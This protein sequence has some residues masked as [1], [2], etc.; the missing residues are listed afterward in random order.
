MSAPSQINLSLDSSQI[1]NPDYLVTKLL[2]TKLQVIFVISQNTSHSFSSLVKTHVPEV[3][4]MNNADNLLL[5]YSTSIA[6]IFNSSANETPVNT[7]STVN[8][9]TSKEDTSSKLKLVTTKKTEVKKKATGSIEQSNCSNQ[10]D[11]QNSDTISVSVTEKKRT[12]K[13][14]VLKKVVTKKS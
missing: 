11:K 14:L 3:Q 7:L 2:E 12:P 13:K 5:K 4:A 1:D 10:N 8:T 6:E 9:S